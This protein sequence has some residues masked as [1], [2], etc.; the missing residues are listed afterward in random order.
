MFIVTNSGKRFDF[1][2]CAPDTIDLRDIGHALSRICRFTGH[3]EEHYS[4]AEHSVHVWRYVKAHGGNLAAQQ[5][6]LM[7]DAAEAYVG[8]VA[9]PL[10][11][12][13]T[14]YMDIEARVERA[15]AD[16]FDLEADPFS[17]HLVKDGDNALLSAELTTL[18]GYYD[19]RSGDGVLMSLPWAE[20]CLQCWP[21][22]LAKARFLSV[23]E[24]LGL[25]CGN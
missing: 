19:W 12:Q 24:E 4:V 2:V 6:A 11:I 17:R 18:M 10:K 1:A 20:A 15:I 21:A 16:R 3:S 25:S 7:H 5:L 23:A 14:E 13:L 9:K 22:P 8:D